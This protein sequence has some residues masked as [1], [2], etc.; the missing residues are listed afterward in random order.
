MMWLYRA[1]LR[2]YPAS[3]RAEYG[4]D[5]CACYAR[6]SWM[7]VLPDILHNAL[8]AHFDIL[9]KDLS[10]TVRTL[11]RSPGF[12]ATAVTVAALGIGATTT[13][14]TLTDHVL[15]RPLPFADA[16]RLVKIWEE[17]RAQ[18]I[19]QWEPSP[20]NFHDW[21]QS[22]TSFD[23]MG[24]YASQSLNLT[25]GSGEPERLEGA[26]VTAE[27]LPML[28]VRPPVGRL[29]TAEDDRDTAPPTILLSDALWHRRFGA[30]P[31]VIGQTLRLDDAVHRI[32]GVLPPAFQF[33]YRS[34]QFWRPLRFGESDYE[35]RDNSYLRVIARLKPGMSL[36]AA[37]A[38]MR[39]VAASIERRW[40][41]ENHEVTATVSDL[42]DELRPAT[43]LML[44]A[45][46]GAAFCVLLIGCSNLANLLMARAVGRRCELAVRAAI[47]AGRERLI[48]QLLT[49]SL[50]ISL[51]GG[52]AGVGLAALSLPLVARLVPTSL[53]ISEVPSIDL[54]VLAF[55]L[56][57]TLAT[58]LAFGVLPALRVC[59]S[60]DFTGLREGARGGTRRTWLR[61]ALVVIEVA[62]CVVLL[63]ASGLF[64]RAIWRVRSID[65]GFRAEGVLTMRTVLPVPK[66]N[67]TALRWQLYTRVLEQVR[68]LPGVTGAGYTSFLPLAPHGGVWKVDIPGR[69]TSGPGYRALGRFVTPEYLEAMNIPLHLGRGITEADTAQRPAVAV[70]NEAAARRFWP[71]ENPIG[72]HI[73]YAFADRTVVGV[74]ADIRARGLER[75]AEP[76]IFLSCQ[77]I[78]DGFM[79]WFAPKDL[80]VRA[81]NASALAAPIRRIIAQADPSLPVSDVH[82]LTELVEGETASRLVQTRVLGGFALIAFLL[83]GVGIHGLLSFA[84]GSR[85]QEIGVRMALGAQRSAIMRMVVGSAARQAAIG[86]T[87]GAALAYV[88]GKDI[89][90]LLAGVSPTDLATYAAAIAVCVVM[91]LA[92]ALSSARRAIAVDPAQVVKFNT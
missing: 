87:I 79:I 82:L 9:R 48:R 40:P 67:S 19:S 64:L 71:G 88:A 74:I 10:Y 12:A 78:P 41:K 68:P 25:G 20:A 14:F 26:G 60:G 39:L 42:R 16:S 1:L 29:F 7:T 6:Q 57:L 63:V 27:L 52:A 5:L 11:R 91:T 53:P 51:I 75:L 30:D 21:K 62:G 70:V 23:A 69:D 34:M 54:R 44:Q 4:E 15:L 17:H 8:A 28:G 81:A 83:A 38:E 65:P 3:F 31:N 73:R 18:G 50:V 49:E 84:V 80:V 33:P 92:G 85:V 32:I 55:A 46:L 90:A 59:A 66:Y 37:Q 86:V 76:Q 56:I 58:G 35:E 2:L 77:Q 22:A 36:M 24:A 43:R 45:L 61:S 13:A 47:G 72:R 89:E